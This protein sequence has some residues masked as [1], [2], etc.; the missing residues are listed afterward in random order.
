MSSIEFLML[1]FSCFSLWVVDLS[2]SCKLFHLLGMSCLILLWKV[3]TL[4]LFGYLLGLFVFGKRKIFCM[5][6]IHIHYIQGVPKK[7]GIRT[8]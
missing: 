4:R 2:S 7:M 5:L 1:F 6:I 8:F 3:L